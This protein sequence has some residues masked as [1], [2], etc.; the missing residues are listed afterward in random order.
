MKYFFFRLQINQ[1]ILEKNII[2][3]KHKYHLS[4]SYEND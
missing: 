1:S 2:I 3:E 4:I